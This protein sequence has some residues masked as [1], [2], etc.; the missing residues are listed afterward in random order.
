M[1]LIVS[2]VLPLVAYFAVE[3]LYG[4]MWGAAV[5]ALISVAAIGYEYARK[6]KVSVMHLLDILLIAAF[7]GVDMLC[8]DMADTMQIAVSLYAAS[9]FAYAFSFP[10]R[11]SAISDM[12]AMLKNRMA[13]SPYMLLRVRESFRRMAVWAAGVG[14]LFML[15]CF[16]PQVAAFRSSVG[17]QAWLCIYIFAAY[18]LTEAFVRAKHRKL[19]GKAEW[20]PLLDD[21]Y[22]LIGA[23]PRSFV[24]KRYKWL[25][26]VVHLHVM[27]EE[28]DKLLL[29]LRPLSKDIQPGK[30]D[31]T[32]G[33]HVSAGEKIADALQREALEEAGLPNF[34]AQSVARYIWRCPDEHEAVISFYTTDKPTRKPTAADEIAEQRYW[35]KAELADNIG[36]GVFTPNLEHEL[37]NYILK[38][39]K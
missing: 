4:E 1:Y 10:S 6:R 9:V 5:A 32:V 24:H 31:T 34:T 39:M 33:G 3:I 21:D 27:T 11:E 19:Y 12:L 38:L 7:F 22:N 20:V 25:H 15:I 37:S 35:T 29:Q 18:Y 26:P 13:K 8:G 16:V 36:K 14:T 17:G 28:R 23:A 30:W 2:V